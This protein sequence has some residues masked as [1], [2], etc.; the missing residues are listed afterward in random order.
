MKVFREQCELSRQEKR[1]N[2]FQE[3][4]KK[5]FSSRYFCTHTSANT[6]STEKSN[7]PTSSQGFACPGSW[8]WRFRPPIF[9]PR[10]MPDIEG[11]IFC[12]GILKQ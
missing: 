1:K 4:F 5:V 3:N 7:F 11:N 8:N 2:F 12:S 6:A 10:S 9:V